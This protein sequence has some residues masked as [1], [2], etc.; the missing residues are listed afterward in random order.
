MAHEKRTRKGIYRSTLNDGLGKK[1]RVQVTV[2]F[3]DYLIGGRWEE[4]IGAEEWHKVEKAI[5]KKYHGWFHTCFNRPKQHCKA[6]SRKIAVRL[7]SKKN[8]VS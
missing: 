1:F 7:I 8:R 6:C 4:C 3:T 2:T 5:E